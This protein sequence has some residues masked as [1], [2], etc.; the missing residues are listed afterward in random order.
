MTFSFNFFLICVSA[1]FE[2]K[3]LEAPPD[4]IKAEDM[5]NVTYKFEVKDAFYPWAVANGYFDGAGAGDLE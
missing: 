2:M 4:I 1:A 5:F 3:W